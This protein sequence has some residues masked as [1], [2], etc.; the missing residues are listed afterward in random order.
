MVRRSKLLPQCEIIFV[1]TPARIL[2]DAHAPWHT[3]IGW[4]LPGAQLRGSVLT[5]L[6]ERDVAVDALDVA[7]DTLRAQLYRLLA[8]SL[9]GA[10]ST[11]DLLACAS[12]TG[13]TSP[14]GRAISAF[15][16]AAAETSPKALARDYQ[17]LFI[18]L[19]RGE[20]VPYGSYYL[21]GFLQEKPLARLRQ[22][23]QR[24]GIQSDLTTSDPEDHLASVLA[25]FAGLI[26]G[27]FSAPLSLDDQK[28][29][30]LRHIKSWVPIFFRDLEAVTSSK[31]YSALGSVGR[32]FLD[33]EDGAFDMI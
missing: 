2:A 5:A 23:F 32:A 13:D 1:C 16:D 9:H 26:D 27:A 8:K 17:D 20:L 11:S 33:I 3:G 14:L 19:G 18:G 29:F 6:A 28:E 31:F 4:R 15:A 25:A 21:T 24:L 10:P 7:E 12:L 22:D 30:Y